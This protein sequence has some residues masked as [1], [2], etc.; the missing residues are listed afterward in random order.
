MRA[1]I[2]KKNERYGDKGLKILH[3]YQFW[4]KDCCEDITK[5]VVLYWGL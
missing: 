3:T 1:S 4:C 2:K 5:Y